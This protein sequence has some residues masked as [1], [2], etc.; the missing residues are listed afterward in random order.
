MKVLAHRRLH[1]EVNTLNNLDR[2]GS[3]TGDDVLEGEGR[4]RWSGRLQ[5]ADAAPERLLQRPHVHLHARNA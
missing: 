4:V 2:F 5:V 3:S 1:S